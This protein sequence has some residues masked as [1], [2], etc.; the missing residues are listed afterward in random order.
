L[1]GREF[2]PQ[3]KKFA[4]DQP[5]RDLLTHNKDALLNVTR[6]G[7]PGPFLGINTQEQLELVASLLDDTQ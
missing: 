1:V 2:V 4:A 3:L 7:D 5:L 6:A